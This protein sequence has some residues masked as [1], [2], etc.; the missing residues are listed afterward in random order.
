MS[1][2][3]PDPITGRITVTTP[4][5]AQQAHVALNHKQNTD[6]L[7]EH[8]SE[9]WET[10]STMRCE[11]FRRQLATELVTCPHCEGAGKV[12]RG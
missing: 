12:L 8:G 6:A 3:T 10:C 7:G 2:L 1:T 9:R 11:G 5:E 4:E